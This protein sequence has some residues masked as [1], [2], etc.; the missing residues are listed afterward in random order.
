[1]VG[2][3]APGPMRSKPIRYLFLDEVD[4]YPGDV[5]SEGDLISLARKNTN[6]FPKK[7]IYDFDAND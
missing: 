5:G 2:S 1:M 4:A 6:I 7:N 3:N